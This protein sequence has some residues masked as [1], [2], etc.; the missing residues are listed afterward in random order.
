MNTINVTL[1]TLATAGVSASVVLLSKGDYLAAGVTGF[2]GILA[3]LAYE[4][5]PVK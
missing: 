4:L 3:Y 2:L 1:Q 5:T